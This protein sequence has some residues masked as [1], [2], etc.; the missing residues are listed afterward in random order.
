MIQIPYASTGSFGSIFLDYLHEEQKLKPFYKYAP[1]IASFESIIAHRKKQSINRAVLLHVLKEQY[2]SID[3]S[4][5]TLQNIAALAD[6]N[7][8]TITTG[9]QLSL[10]TGELY[11]IYKIITCINLAEKAAAANQGNK[12][13]PVFWMASEDHDFEEINHAN[14]AGTKFEWKAQSGGAVGELATSGIDQIIDSIDHYLG[15]QAGKEKII[16]LFKLA[17]TEQKSLAAATRILVNELFKQYGLVIIDANH[18]L[19]KKEFS[20]IIRSDIFEQNS[21]HQV[22]ATNTLLEKQYPIQVNPR[23]INFFYLSENTRSRIIKTE[24][25]F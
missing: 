16:Q 6:E 19:L 24:T 22:T 13:V 4:E 9:H 10:F 23:E 21:F 5:L 25:C 18:P 20:E 1:N 8:F 15:N 3:A 14:I 7:T 12:V 17:Y 2:Q 11:F